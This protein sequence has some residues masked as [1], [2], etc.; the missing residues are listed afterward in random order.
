M[1]IVIS[2]P[3]GAGKTTIA[4]MIRRHFPE[5]EFSVSATT[6]PKRNNEQHG[7]D[8]YFLSPEQFEE[9]EREGAFVET[10]TVFGNRYGTL[11]SE[12][13][14][15]LHQDKHVLFDVDVK[16]ALSLRRA[17]PNDSV[18][19][20]LVPPSM[21]ALQERLVHRNA[22]SESDIALRLERAEW[23]LQQAPHFDFTVVNG[24]LHTAVNEVARYVAKS[25]GRL[26]IEEIQ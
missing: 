20:F 11:K 9:W 26:P 5:L 23:E 25:I 19:I 21:D 2:A 1:L 17:Y 8:Y 15:R 18:L 6:R 3:S 13:E 16:G 24:D 12:I 4:Q 7:T 10:E 14:R 22:N